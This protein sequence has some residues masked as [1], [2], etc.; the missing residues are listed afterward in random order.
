MGKTEIKSGYCN[1]CKKEITNP[2]RKPMEPM[3]KTIWTIIIVATLGFAAIV[4]L[5]YQYGVK[6][7]EY[8]PTCGLKLGAKKI[9]VEPPKKE[10]E[11][12]VK[13]TT[14]RPLKE[15]SPKKV[16][17]PK[18]QKETEFEE[19]SE[20]KKKIFCDYCGVDLSEYEEGELVVCPNCGSSFK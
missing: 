14:P 16:I 2:S 1:T 7:K 12:P 19:V 13:P 20:E 10:P 11:K 4:L 5:I 18:Q 15:K 3:E 8:C 9:E 6:K 17:A